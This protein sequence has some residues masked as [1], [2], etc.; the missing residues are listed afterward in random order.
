MLKAEGGFYIFQGS[1]WYFEA[2]ISRSE[3]S[4]SNPP[5]LKFGVKKGL[6][7]P[8]LWFVFSVGSFWQLLSVQAGGLDVFRAVLN[9]ILDI[10]PHVTPM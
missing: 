5:M 10:W 8:D 1:A 9:H 2:Q 3:P 6:W 4:C 7:N